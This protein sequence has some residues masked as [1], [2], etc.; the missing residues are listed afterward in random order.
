MSGPA[1]VT[2]SGRASTPFRRQWATAL[3]VIGS[4][5]VGTTTRACRRSAATW[6]MAPTLAPTNNRSAVAVSGSPASTSDR[7]RAVNSSTRAA[8]ADPSTTAVPA[9]GHAARPAATAPEASRA[10]SVGSS[11]V[12]NS[13]G[14]TPF[15]A[16]RR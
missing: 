6:S 7:P 14:N 2:K 5:P 3:V 15:P 8:P 4:G 13:P 16:V 9:S 12:P 1:V 10:A 11:R